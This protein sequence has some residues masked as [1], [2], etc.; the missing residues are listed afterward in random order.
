MHDDLAANKVTNSNQELGDGWAAE[1]DYGNSR[2]SC[3]DFLSSPAC[4]KGSHAA[5]N[6]RLP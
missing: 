6:V 2:G 5:T 1:E 3:H 4:E